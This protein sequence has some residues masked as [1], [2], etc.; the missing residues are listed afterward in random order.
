MA[1]PIVLGSFACSSLHHHWSHSNPARGLQ[2]LCLCSRV[3]PPVLPH[4]MQPAKLPRKLTSTRDSQ[5][6][7]WTLSCRTTTLAPHTYV[8]KYIDTFI[9]LQKWEERKQ[10]CGYFYANNET[11]F[12]HLPVHRRARYET[13][14]CKQESVTTDLAKARDRPRH[15]LKQDS[16]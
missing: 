7:S 16:L 2:S 6:A 8:Q 9:S 11:V 3:C 14:E 4:I 13:P 12:Y 1:L 15:S 5:Q 10:L